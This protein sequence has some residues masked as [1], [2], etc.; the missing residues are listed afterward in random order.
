MDNCSQI[1]V[2]DSIEVTSFSKIDDESE[3][4]PIFEIGFSN[5]VFSKVI[6]VEKNVIEALYTEPQFYNE[7][8]REF[9]LVYDIMYAK[10]GTEPVVESLYRTVENQE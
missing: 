6:L 5:G 3:I 10:C 7:V 2:L 9:C 1:K 4:N 8:G